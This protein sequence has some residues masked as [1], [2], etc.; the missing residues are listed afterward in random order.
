MIV[1]LASCAQRVAPFVSVGKELPA[2]M[3]K[4]LVVKSCRARL[5]PAG[6]FA[7]ARVQ[8]SKALAVLLIGLQ[9]SSCAEDAATPAGS[10]VR[11]A[12]HAQPNKGFA[13]T[14][15]TPGIV[16]S[17]TDELGNPANSFTGLIELRLLQNSQNAFVISGGRAPVVDGVAAFTSLTINKAGDNFILEASMVNDAAVPKVLSS[18]FATVLPPVVIDSTLLQLVNDSAARRTGLFEFVPTG[19]SVPQ[20][21][22]GSV[23]VGAESGGFLRKATSVV[24]QPNLILV[25]TADAELTDVVRDATIEDSVRVTLTDGDLQ[26]SNPNVH[27]GETTINTAASGLSVRNG[28]VIFD[29]FTVINAN[30]VRLTV[31]TGRLRFEPTF[32]FRLD[33]SAF[34]VNLFESSARGTLFFDAATE[35]T[36]STAI[37]RSQSFPLLTVSKTF[38]A[39]VAGPWP[40]PVVG[41]V[42]LTL[43][44]T[45]NSSADGRVVLTGNIS[46]SS[47]VLAGARWQDGQWSLLRNHSLSFS[48]S[49][50]TPS[51]TISTSS[52]LGARAELGVTYYK[53]VG[54]YIFGSVFGRH[55]QTIDLTNGRYATRCHVGGEVG[56]GF[57]VRFL[58]F[59]LARFEQS[60][61]AP[62]TDIA[63]CTGSFPLPPASPSNLTGSAVSAT[64]AH[65]SWRDNSSYE[66]E[67]R[68]ERRTGAPGQWIRI[69]TLPA[70]RTTHSDAGLAPNTPYTYR[71]QAC[72]GSACSGHS[73]ETSVVTQAAPQYTVLTSSMPSQGGSTSGGGTFAPNARVTV[74]ASPANGYVF[75]N[76]NEH[77]SVVATN[78]SYTFN[79]MSHRTLVAT[80]NQT[81][82]NY[83]LTVSGFGNGGGQVVGNG[84]NCQVTQGVTSGTCTISMAANTVVTLSALPVNGHMFS[85]WSGPCSGVGTCQFSMTQSRAVSAGFT[86]STPTY[87]V[88]T[89]SNPAN[90]GSTAGGGIHAAGTVVNVSATP[91]S[92]YS[93]ASWTEGSTVVS[94]AS[95]YSFI[96]TGNRVLTANFT[97]PNAY[98]MSVAGGSSGGAGT[99]AGNGLNCQISNGTSGLCSV[100]LP[101]NTN[102]V[103][104]ATPAAGHSFVG[105]SGPCTGTGNCQFSISQNT[106]ITANFA[107][108]VV[109]YL[110]STSSSPSNAGTTTGAG[111]YSSGS[112]VTVTAIAASGFDFV[113]WTE[114]TAIVSTSESYTFSA[115]SNRA[116][117]ANFAPVTSNYRLTIGG[118]GTAGG[119]VTGNGLN[120]QIS[121]GNATG[122]CSASFAEGTQITLTVAPNS[123][124][125]FGG[126]T[127]NGVLIS[128]GNP[129]SFVLS[130]D[131]ILLAWLQPVQPSYALT[132]D[133]PVG[134]SG[135]GRLRSSPAGIDCVLPRG[136]GTS[137]DCSEVF[138]AG[139]AV[140][141]TAVPDPGSYVDSWYYAC[142]GATGSACTVTLNGPTHARVAFDEY[143]YVLTVAG[144]GNG[145]GTIN[146]NVGGI[147]CSYSN[148]VIVSGPCS[149]GGLAIGTSVTLTAAPA[150]GS[151]FGGWSGDCSGTA[152]NCQFMMTQNR[153]AT[154]S[155]SVAPTSGNL[156]V[157]NIVTGPNQ[158]SGPFTVTVDA[159]SAA[160]LV[161]TIVKNGSVSLSGLSSGSHDVRLTGQGIG[162]NTNCAIAGGFAQAVNVPANATA[163]LSYSIICQ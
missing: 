21:D 82:T 68:L 58:S 153:S 19:A 127:Q 14:A 80:F 137:G 114:G 42:R 10:G 84:I 123:G 111:T 158:P 103:L 157:S 106:T 45:A 95:T 161:R 44:V 52:S 88:S 136:G 50:F 81:T 54:A 131:R 149:W 108:P 5:T 142:A 133:Q 24:R 105:W 26:G 138:P 30:D 3:R 73:A 39:I 18:P 67:I 113:N 6:T 79:V 4:P 11:L 162:P 59:T 93:F 65:L 85:G 60:I 122:T 28:E 15:L 100:N 75:V 163:A 74:A 33:V 87:T 31:K 129:Y 36:F 115:A 61:P 37:S 25:R 101:A 35:A 62:D 151:I 98:A 159:Q 139:T 13:N 102:V 56:A 77:G 89:N 72:N 141:L 104:Q 145:S 43:Y 83:T 109:Q 156:T 135:T 12:F 107:P 70:N 128:A 34:R 63:A 134:R 32:I 7:R 38:V 27:W 86:G 2:M 97:P 29:N 120:C 91:A 66:S 119:R 154:A 132:V 94:S 140:Q 146:S 76:W 64:Q 71:V 144:S 9:M 69:A 78:S 150:A 112:S 160:P 53:T 51:A 23:I 49:P 96:V 57:D 40:L 118:F 1:H 147:R 92:G 46:G 17:V 90:G 143:T 22:S 125:T 126:W 8:G 110:I 16:V 121:N 155:F 48:A 41:D 130:A 117:V 99:V 148:G 55:G 152:L 116:L 20:I 124:A 47:T